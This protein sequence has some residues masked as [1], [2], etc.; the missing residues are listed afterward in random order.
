MASL[1]KMTAEK[2]I[3]HTIIWLDI[4]LLAQG[5]EDVEVLKDLK[6]VMTPRRA[7]LSI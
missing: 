2:C 3:V 6:S 4:D 7:W 5:T 1:G